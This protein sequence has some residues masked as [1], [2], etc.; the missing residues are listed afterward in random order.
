MLLDDQ[1]ATN[2]AQTL[3]SYFDILAKIYHRNQVESPDLPLNE[4]QIGENNPDIDP[5]KEVV[6]KSS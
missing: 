2:V 3:V 4:G 1:K 5:R 6:G